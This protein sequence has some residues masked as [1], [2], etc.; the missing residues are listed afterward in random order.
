MS[1]R[2]QDEYPYVATQVIRNG[3]VAAFN[4]GDPVPEAV[5]K[6][7]GYLDA[8]LVVPRDEWDGRSEDEPERAM[9]RG[10]MPPHLRDKVAKDADKDEPKSGD[11]SATS[12]SVK[13]GGASRKTPDTSKSE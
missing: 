12:K 9:T 11:T 2:P 8:G 1:H 3:M 10:E 4:E 13:T 6:R 7:E 5:V